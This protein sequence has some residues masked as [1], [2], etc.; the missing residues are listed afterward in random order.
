MRILSLLWISS[1]M[2]HVQRQLACITLVSSDYLSQS[3][4]NWGLI[5]SEID[6]EVGIPCSPILNLISKLAISIKT[7]LLLIILAVDN[8][9]TLVHR[10]IFLIH[11]SLWERTEH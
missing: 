8:N 10:Y 4:V 9:H 3:H 7:T 11:E 5:L 6:N 1:G 2:M